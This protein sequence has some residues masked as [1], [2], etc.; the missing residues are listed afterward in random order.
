[1]STP[2]PWYASEAALTALE[3]EVAQAAAGPAVS[4]LQLALAW[5]LR[6]RQPARASAL[7]ETLN[8]QP[9]PPEAAA[10]RLLLSAELALAG[11]DLAGAQRAGAAA[12]ADFAA[13]GS[14]I[15]CADAHALHAVLA[16]EG[17]DPQRQLAALREMQIAAGD[18]IE[19]AV[20]AAAWQARV[21]A[22]A[23]LAGAETA[24]A[25][26]AAEMP[27]A[28]PS[29]ARS[30]VESLHATLAALKG[31]FGVA[32][33]HSIEAFRLAQDS[34]Q[35]H[36]SIL[37]AC[38]IAFGFS[39]IQDY[40][41]A[42]EWSA[43]A[44]DVAGRLGLRS[45]R[46]AAL[47]AAGDCLRR[48]DRLADARELLQEARGLVAHQPHARGHGTLLLRLGEL[49]LADQQVSDAEACFVELQAHAQAVGNADLLDHAHVG[50]AAALLEQGRLK[51]AQGFAQAV[52]ERPRVATT[53]RIA[54]FELLAKLHELH[55]SY[56]TP[57]G[58]TAA[59]T[60]L[61]LLMEAHQLAR[62]L[63][64]YRVP[65]S[66]LDALARA[67][68]KR[69]EYAQA[70]DFAQQANAARQAL[71]QKAS[72]HR[73]L[74][75][76]V[77]RD[78]QRMQVEAERQRLEAEAQSRRSALLQQANEALERLGAIGRDI[79]AQQDPLAVCECLFTHTQALMAVDCFILY[80][81]QAQER[82]LQSL[83][84]REAG[85]PMAPIRRDLD[86]AGSL[87]ARCARE[88]RQLNGDAMQLL[89]GTQA[90]LSAMFTPLMLDD[91]LLGVL[92]IQARHK[93]AYDEREQAMLRSLSAFAAIGLANAQ[94]LEQLR[95][96][97][98]QTAQQEKLASLGELVVSLAQE[99][100]TPM[101][102]ISAGGR[103]IAE[104]LDQLLQQLPPLLQQ[105]DPVAQGL[106]A[107]LLERLSA[108]HTSLNI[109][110]ERMQRRQL[111][112]ALQQA[113][114]SDARQLADVL[115]PL[116]AGEP[117]DQLLP[118][119][120]HPQRERI[121]YLA[122]KLALL[123]SSTA[124]VN[125]AA[126]RATR[127]VHALKCYARLEQSQ[128]LQALDL[129]DSLDTVLT[130]YQHRFR[131]GI[132]LCS[133]F[134]A[135]PPLHAH[136]AELHRL[137]TL[138]LDAAMQ[139]LRAPGRLEWTLTRDGMHA[140]L[141]VCSSA[142]GIDTDLPPAMQKITASHGGNIT[143][144]RTITQGRKFTVRLPYT[145][146]NT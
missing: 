104:L 8:A 67:H 25:A 110:D 133:R 39:N 86:Q 33:P 74:A 21:L 18:D 77:Q 75:L 50:L 10:R 85:R 88:R 49:H 52:V 123:L 80:R 59:A 138:L 14:G 3:R 2:L 144:E 115:L 120:R 24:A 4:Q 45:G 62:G 105:L 69:G 129:R 57:S 12:L 100:Q 51:E 125:A 28:L 58:D 53:R 107:E 37:L 142:A 27:R 7:L 46:A 56:P 91:R 81:V 112:Q 84:A 11:G 108:S 122:R 63:A 124:N 141:T 70:L 128:G 30:Q 90:M 134:E 29:S 1:M 17:G 5:Q 40:Q 68:A 96:T 95:R 117:L 103:G 34:G 61:R 131:H 140:R 99:V 126:D 44:Q 98:V 38:N 78:A 113:G 23:D 47:S 65:V 72:S 119:L 127:V 145:R 89:P 43:L 64:D 79:L 16:Y 135:L 9:L 66:L 87:A 13:I 41:A 71:H 118:L 60:S 31:D 54:A 36:A 15:G 82:C 132:E 55:P 94:R 20:A 102:V 42:L 19:R 106:L 109:R 6:Q 76:G 26:I 97:Q 139:G 143:V 137:W 93:D 101:A 35:L 146:E 48:L 130:L 22:F 73:A 121:L 32:V 136:A 111:A 116:G 92:T 114:F 83:F